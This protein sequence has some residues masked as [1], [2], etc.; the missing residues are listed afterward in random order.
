MEAN[1]SPKPVIYGITGIGFLSTYALLVLTGMVLFNASLHNRTLFLPAQ[2]NAESAL[3]NEFVP[4]AGGEDV[5]AVT[6]RLEENAQ[7][8]GKERVRVTRPPDPGY[9][10]IDIPL[11]TPIHEE[12]AIHFEVRNDSSQKLLLYTD[13]IEKETPE[14]GGAE[15]WRAYR[16]IEPHQSS[17]VRILMPELK[18]NPNWSID[19][20][21]GNGE[22][23]YENFDRLEFVFF[24]K[25]PIDFTLGPIEASSDLY[26][27]A[28][29]GVFALPPLWFI[30][31]FAAVVDHRKR[32][33]AL[34]MEWMRLVVFSSAVM[35]IFWLPGIMRHA[36]RDPYFP[37]VALAGIAITEIAIRWF[38]PVKPFTRQLIAY[39]S[40]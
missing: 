1:R 35:A 16:E 13:F 9:T 5:T 15:I 12:D 31:L 14:T 18:L 27:H 11:R 36:S 21:R 3:L 25:S 30:L 19:R 7:G 2:L 26:A 10:G 28:L 38:Y 32:T 22:I 6:V 4:W 37:I 20:L 17:H 33:F 29:W 34:A 40:P 8:G 39:I 24:E 23:D